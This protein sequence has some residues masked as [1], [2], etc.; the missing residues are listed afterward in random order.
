MD[1]PLPPLHLKLVTPHGRGHPVPLTRRHRRQAT[2]R[3]SRVLSRRELFA[4][5]ERV[6]TVAPGAPLSFLVVM[7]DGL[8]DLPPV[9][10]E[11]TG[12]LVAGRITSLTR[13]VD[14]VGRMGEAAF[15]VLLQGSGATAAG[16]VAARLS[17]HVSQA[18]HGLSAELGVRVS[19][20]TGTGANWAT[21]PVAATP[22]LPDCG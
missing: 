14:T 1:T 2:D 12:H 6:G 9:E 4:T 11:L 8:A 22:S 17:Y 20:A 10:S 13:A 5:V 18:L 19:A 21:L 15:G 3:R 16:A 7:V